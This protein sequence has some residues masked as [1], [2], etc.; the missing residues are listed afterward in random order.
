MV[1]VIVWFATCIAKPVPLPP[2]SPPFGNH[3]LFTDEDGNVVHAFI[4]GNQEHYYVVAPSGSATVTNEVRAL[5]GMEFET[6]YPWNDG[7]DVGPCMVRVGAARSG[8]TLDGK[9]WGQT[10]KI[11]GSK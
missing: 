7:S 8:R 3:K 4:V 2:N 10:P 11:G 1:V 9:E 5:D 6:R